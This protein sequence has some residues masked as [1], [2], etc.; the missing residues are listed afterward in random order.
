MTED[1][2]GRTGHKTEGQINFD[3]VRAWTK[4]VHQILLK[5]RSVVWTRKYTDRQSP[6]GFMFGSKGYNWANFVKIAI[7][8]MHTRI[9]GTRQKD[10]QISHNVAKIAYPKELNS[11]LLAY[12]VWR[13]SNSVKMIFPKTLI[14]LKEILFFVVKFDCKASRKA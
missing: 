1:K 6:F 13:T 10:R 7:S 11:L 2:K 5:L 14:S 3:S 9:Y 4:G 8:R 12:E